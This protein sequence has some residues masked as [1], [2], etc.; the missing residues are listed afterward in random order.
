MIVA[1]RSLDGD[2]AEIVRAL[3]LLR[4]ARGGRPCLDCA[5]RGGRLDVCEAAR[6]AGADRR[7]RLRRG[8]P[9]AA[10]RRLDPVRPAR[11]RAA[12]AAAAAGFLGLGAAAAGLLLDRRRGDRPVPALP[13]RAA[14]L[15]RGMAVAAQGPRG[16]AG[17]RRTGARRRGEARELLGEADA[18][19]AAGPLLRSRAPAPVPQHRGHR[20]APARPRPAGA[21]QPR[22]RR[23]GRDPRAGRARRSRGSRCW[24]SAACSPRRPLAA[25]DWRDCRAAY[26]DFAFAEGWR[27]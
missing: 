1:R 23:A 16:G 13:D 19:A 17:R 20:F 6:S 8:A 22:H 14:A 5:A 24:S 2:A 10:R 27:G 25:G 4:L 9:P 15:G 7:R 12:A 18:L 3:R 26:E 21:D 11:G